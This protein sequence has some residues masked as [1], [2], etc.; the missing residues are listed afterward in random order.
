MRIYIDSA[1]ITE[2]KEALATGFVYGVTTNPTLLRRA[3]VRIADVAGLARQLFELGAKELHLQTYSADADAIVREGTDLAALDPQ[4]VVV[5]IPAVP[6]GY[7][8]A[9]RLSNSWLRVTMTAVY[10]VRQVVLAQAAGARYVAVYVGRMR[11]SGFDALQLIGQMQH[12]INI[13]DSRLEI[14]AASVRSPEELDA[15]AE[16]GVATVTLPWKVL[17]RL[18][19]SE[20]TETA[21][22]T[23]FEDAKAIQ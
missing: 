3:S 1:D 12:T 18:A 16:L 20:A 17:S 6:E 2:I 21:A 8:A 4:R 23:F 14:L 13:Q 7:A 22:N 9:A 10:T 19:A 5:K 11:D 15:L